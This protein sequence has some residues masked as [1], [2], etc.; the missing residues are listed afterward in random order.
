MLAG[1]WP[2]KGLNARAGRVGFPGGSTRRFRSP[3][4]SNGLPSLL[5]GRVAVCDVRTI[6]RDVGV[7]HAPLR[8]SPCVPGR[9]TPMNLSSTVRIPLRL[10]VVAFAVVAL[11]GATRTEAAQTSWACIPNGAIEAPPN[12]S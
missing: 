12:N 2:K 10:L 8:I 1:P 9:E 4:E 11:L 5:H 3:L 7:R 6:V